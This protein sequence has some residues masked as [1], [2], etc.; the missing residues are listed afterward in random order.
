[1]TLGTE[2]RPPHPWGAVER[3]PFA[4]ALVPPPE[5]RSALGDVRGLFAGFGRAPQRNAILALGAGMVIVIAANIVGQVYLNRWQG[6]FFDAVEQK[7]L[8]ALGRQLV[9]FVVIIASLLALVVAQT[10]L[11]EVLKIRLREWLTRRLLDDWLLPGRAYRLAL[12]A[13]EGVNPDQRLQEDARHASDLTVDLAVGALHHVFLLASFIGVLWVLSRD[14]AF[15]IGGAHVA[16]PGYMVWCA[17]AYSL[18][19]SVVTWLVGRPLIRLNAERYAREAD[20][21]FGLMRVSERA[22][23]IGLY[24]GEADE[25][26]VLDATLRR[27]LDSVRHLALGLARLTWITAGYGWLAL[28]VPI[29]VA[30]PGYLWG[31]LTLGG[32]MRVVGAFQQVQQALRW[33]VDGFPRIADWRAALHRVMAFHDAMNVLDEIEGEKIEIA[34]HPEGLLAFQELSILLADGRVV[35]A[36]ATAT[37]HPGERVLL[38]GESGSGKS[39]LFRAIAGLWPW[40]SGRILLPKRSEMMFMPQ[41]PYLP[42][43]TLRAVLCYP[44]S[45][46]AFS[47]DVI[48]AALQ[49][50]GLAELEAVL[51]RDERWD[52]MLSMGQQQGVA[53]ARLLLHAPHWIFMDE[54]TSA[55]D[56]E[57]ERRVMSIFDD[58]LAEATVLS[59]AHRPSLESFHQRVLQLV[60]SP[61]GAKL[62]RR[63][64][65]SRG[66]RSLGAR[67]RARLTRGGT[68]DAEM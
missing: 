37:L 61:E 23:A 30:L 48:E 15:E 58:A 33:F 18:V 38:V 42:L 60:P 46:G 29:L 43:G 63:T 47:D 55:L 65:P 64:P 49:R 21:R 50:V 25:R 11:H 52:Q 6:A 20:L 62:Q 8:P 40:G 66:R 44:A 2:R 26:R 10:W 5:Q 28:V 27:V 16:I 68:H 1:L 14:V 59:I 53:F 22:E 36:E 51:D 41:R 4:G 35:I 3:A 34:D 12:T 19:G 32:L 54:A 45:P 17:L 67:L 57:S 24:G 7:D 9:V 39:T 56:P 31:A 13:E